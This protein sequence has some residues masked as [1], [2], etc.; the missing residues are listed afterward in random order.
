[1][2]LCTALL[3]NTVLCKNCDE[4]VTQFELASFFGSYETFWCTL[5]CF[6]MLLEVL[7]VNKH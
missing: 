4:R 1:M 5:Q 3:Y 7:L 6:Y 2:G